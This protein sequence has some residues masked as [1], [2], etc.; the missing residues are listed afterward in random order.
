M[1]SG[2]VVSA[3][4]VGL[5]WV[6]GAWNRQEERFTSMGL[7]R[8]RRGPQLRSVP[9]LQQEGIRAAVGIACT[10]YIMDRLYELGTA[11]EG[12]AR[13][14]TQR[15]SIKW[16]RCRMQRRYQVVQRLSDKY[17]FEP[18]SEDRI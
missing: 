12:Q 9:G 16:L 6:C 2:Y 13:S 4:A 18:E 1:S 8:C 7:L 11:S 5:F 15:V 10:S 14:T 3:F 17:R